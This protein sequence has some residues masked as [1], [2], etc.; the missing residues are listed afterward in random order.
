MP[1]RRKTD[2]QLLKRRS[3]RSLLGNVRSL[4]GAFPNRTKLVSG[5][6]RRL[7]FCEMLEE[8]TML[9]ADFDSKFIEHGLLNADSSAIRGPIVDHVAVAVLAVCHSAADSHVD[10][11]HANI[12][13]GSNDAAIQPL[14]SEGT[15]VLR[16]LQQQSGLSPNTYGPLRAAPTWTYSVGGESIAIDPSYDQFVVNVAGELTSSAAS[17]NS[18]GLDLSPD[19]F[20]TTNTALVSVDAATSPTQ[21][22]SAISSLAGVDWAGP[23]FINSATGGRM[24]PT[25]E[26]IVSLKAGVDA[27]EFFATG[28]T[29]FKRLSGTA[30]QYVATIDI[31]TTFETLTHANVLNQNPSVAW[32]EPN[33]LVEIQALQVPN[34]TRFDTNQWHLRNTGQFGGTA[35]AD[36]NLPDA[37]DIETGDTTNIVIAVLDDGVQLDHPDLNIFTNPGEIPGNGIDDD[38]NGWIDDVHGWDFQNEDNDPSPL[39]PGDNHGTAVAGVAA[40]IGNNDLGVAGATWNATVMP[41]KISRHA[42]SSVFTDQIAAAIYYAAGRTEDASGTWKAADILNNSWKLN[43][44]ANVV[45]DAFAWAESEGRQGTGAVSLVATG[46]DSASSISYP[47]SLPTTIAVGASTNM[48]LRAS[49]S[50]YGPEIDIVAPSS[51]G[52]AR[53]DTT[54]RTGSDGYTPDDY[55][56]AG[57]DGLGG[58]SAATPLVSGVVA[59]MLA[60]NPTLTPDEVRTI[61]RDSA[62]KIGGVNYDNGFHEEYGYGRIDAKA[63]LDLVDAVPEMDVTGNA[64]PINDGDSTPSTDDHT[65]F[66]S[67]VVTTGTISRTFTISNSGSGELSL[68]GDPVVRIDGTHAA[69]FMLSTAPATTVAAK[70]GTTTFT[71]N[72]TPAGIGLREATVSIASNDENES[73]YDFNIQGIGTATVAPEIEVRGN[74]EIIFDGALTS[75]FSDHTD[76]GAA[77]VNGDIVSRV[78]TINN[79]GSSVLNLNG[80]PIVEVGGANPGDFSVTVDPATTVAAGGGATTFTVDFN[81]IAMG[82]RSATI[83]ISN[84]DSDE[85]FFDFAVSGFGESF[86]FGDLPAPYPVTRAEDGARHLNTGPRLGN[87]RDVETDGTHSSSANH[88]DITGSVNDEDGVTFERIAAGQSRAAVSVDISNAP[89]GAF[90]DAWIDFNG[91][92]ALTG[93]Q[94]QIAVSQA[95]QNGNNTLLFEVPAWAREGTTAARFRISSTG[96]LG[97][98][99]A[100]IDGEVEDY[101]VTISGPAPGTGSFSSPIQITSTADGAQFV[102]AIDLDRD[103]DVDVL[104]ASSNDDTIAWYENDGGAGFTKIVIDSGSSLDSVKT[105]HV[106]DVD[107]DGDLDVISGR[108]RSGFIDDS[109]W[110]ENNGSQSFTRR[111]TS[112]LNAVVGVTSVLGADIDGDGDTDLLTAASDL[113][114][115]LLHR[116]DGN[117]FFAS[118]T[119]PVTLGPDNL[120]QIHVADVDSD[121]DLDVLS[122]SFGDGRI[123]WNENL[124]VSGFAPRDVISGGSLQATSVFATDVD[125]DGDT[126][127]I[128]GFAGFDRVDWFENDGA[129]SFTRHTVTTSADFVQQVMAADI[130]GDGDVDLVSSSQSDNKVTWYENNGSESFTT[131]DI[132][133]GAT[134]VQSVFVADVDGDGVLDILSANRD[135]DTIAWYRQTGFDFGDAPDSSQSGFASTYP[136]TLGEDGARHASIGPTLGANRDNGAGIHS[137][138]ANAD[139]TTGT[140]DDE[141]GVTFDGGTITVSL[142]SSLT[143]SVDI[144]LRNADATSNLLDAWIDWNRDGDWDDVGEQ[145]FTSFDLGVTSG[146]ESHDFTIPQDTGFNVQAGTTYAR[147][148]LST[149][150]GLTPTGSAID[151]EVEDHA[152]T[153]VNPTA[154][155]T[156]VFLNEIVVDPAGTTTPDN[157]NEYIEIRGAANQSLQGVYLV[158]VEGDSV[159]SMGEIDAGTSHIIDLSDATMGSNGFLVIADD[160]IDPYSIAAG[161]TIVD[162]S[163]F[164]IEQ[165]SYTALLIHVDET[166]TAP[167]GGQDL[168]SGDDG[169][170]ALPIGWSILDG[171]A[172]LD[173]GESDRAYAQI[174]FSSDGGGLIETGAVV[175]PGGASFANDSIHHVMRIG[176]SSGSTAADWVAF[177]FQESPVPTPPD[178]VI[179][180]S[181]DAAYSAGTITTKHLGE[182]NPTF[183]TTANLAATTHGNEAGPID[184]VFTVTLGTNNVTG[185]PITFDLEDLGTGSATSGGDFAAIAANA[186]ITV[187]PGASTGSLTVPVVNDGLF[188]LTETLDVRISSPSSGAVT[189]GTATATANITDNDVAPSVTLGV[190]HDTIA[191]QGLVGSFDLLVPAYA[192]PASPDGPEIWSSLISAASSA[193][194]HVILNP[195]SGPGASPIDPNYVNDLGSGPVGPVL[196]LK[197]AGGIV[198]GYVATGF[199]LRDLN[200]VKA[201]IDTYYDPAYWRGA[202]VQLDGI[203]FDEMSNDLAN[204][205]YYQQIQAHVLSKSGTAKVISNPGTTFTFDSSGG[206]SGFTV[207]DYANTADTIVTFEN[208]GDEYRNN[209]TDP[210]WLNDFTSDHFAHIIHTEAN[211]A[212]MVADLA[213]ASSRKAGM[214]F[215]TNDTLPN[216]FDN[217]INYWTDT[218]TFTVTLSEP[219]G[220][221]VTVDLGFTGTATLTDDF[222]RSGIQLVIPA[223]GT[224]GSVTVTA[225]EDTTVDPNE[226]IVVDILNVANGTED[227]VQQATTTIE[228]VN[229]ATVS[230]AG[231]TDGEETGPV[232]GVFTVTQT[233][234]AADDTVLTYSVG[235][236]SDSGSDFTALSGTVTISAGDTQATIT[237]PVIDDELF[238]GSESLILTLTGIT[239]S[240]TGVTIDPAANL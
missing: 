121:G 88:D 26:V 78:F 20:L 156:G 198:Y 234:I 69:E 227:A 102:Y 142:T 206:A 205:G 159:A 24:V 132:T 113:D 15:K 85:T 204:V 81:P 107:G 75:N 153:I 13:D 240:S 140:P 117:Q 36:A 66:G 238:E 45:T 11:S 104:S 80:T 183:T 87:E 193:Q 57:F 39:D 122:A 152:V 225:A 71:I 209:Y 212:D 135:S 70:G 163:G 160:D 136:V 58:T 4:I 25:D 150:G 108:D 73:T 182:S 173:G 215:V 170:D 60:R 82:A 101:H 38:G 124:G 181:T 176:D 184:I 186:Q 189:V 47:A 137:L 76:F 22:F 154:A 110:Y 2:N 92:G 99:G 162:V 100:A 64:M 210:A 157:P 86:D 40:A 231:T 34:E 50:N 94:E 16:A 33:F 77:D 59:L 187:A 151:G 109:Y 8:R 230:I 165:S 96:G 144:D 35:N 133:T 233:S 161:T 44:S 123:A 63:A 67:T 48:D 192:N 127:V 207:T 213:L 52:T 232:N 126:D 175:I 179:L 171:I 125:G 229:V 91:D 164:D 93:L 7:A 29:K 226:T 196:D 224:T 220:L 12:D 218:A 158:F 1:R 197:S 203:F 14:E 143:G 23:A 130:D 222:A 128:A 177:R 155:P 149:T 217:S 56:G 166:G 134:A 18:V 200:D 46:N 211:A 27:S 116:N 148:R 98:T 19:K 194:V 49:Y 83:T 138:S 174:V 131:H 41:V 147:F 17:A 237:V 55:T 141:D 208:T 178:F 32:A 190:N 72:F 74:N 42:F 53:I 221:P 112:P 214:L 129:E 37:W 199:A 201:D 51:G 103:G 30:N 97:V 54:D 5:A 145:I 9:A 239:S 223:G 21:T 28:Y 105:L 3:L 188:E 90:L 216:P 139:D 10:S 180:A 89:S 228:N 172:V 84:D 65:D 115:I 95:V 62:A 6:K 119:V 106:A 79:L 195:A 120:Q 235:G 191:E 43:N 185:S 111:I 202:G 169:L 219:S 68:S 61:L 168:D 167:A 31:D 114:R 236:T 146:V 118:N